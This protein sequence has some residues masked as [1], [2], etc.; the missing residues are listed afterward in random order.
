VSAG[1]KAKFIVLAFVPY[2]IA[3]VLIQ[4]IIT[5]NEY[6]LMTTIDRDIPFVPEFIWIYH[7]IIPLTVFTCFLFFQKRKLF[8]LMT[9]SNLVAGTILCFFYVFFPSFYPR[10]DW[11]DTS[12]ISGMMVEFTRI[13]DGA[14]NTFPSGHVTFAWM[15]ALLVSISTVGK[16][17]MSLRII[18]FVWASL[19]SISTLTL[20][21]H[22]LFDVVSGIMLAGIIFY[23]FKRSR[24]FRETGSLI[25]TDAK[26]VPTRITT[27][28]VSVDSRRNTA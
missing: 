23:I 12:T 14:N 3:Y 24:L 10:T 19:I 2:L 26:F 15:L 25:N 22:Y 4:Q 13:I 8:L 6:D 11:V 9:Y 18:Y 28:E 20:K 5:V 7:T 27:G 21:Q 16:K 1:A 17:Y